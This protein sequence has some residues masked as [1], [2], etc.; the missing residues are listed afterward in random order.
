M[1]RLLRRL[2]FSRAFRGLI[3]GARRIVLPGFEGFDAY[4]IARLFFRALREGRLVTRASAISFKLFMAFFPAVL[5][6]LT[7]IPLIPVA[8]LQD[9]LLRM[10]RDLLPP[11]IRGFVESTLHDL[12][13]RPH[14]TLFSFSFVGGLYLASNSVDAILLGFSGS[15]NLT[16]WHSPWKQRLLSVLLLLVLSVLML[17]A[18]PIFATGN[19][20]IALLVRHHLLAGGLQVAALFTVK[21]IV[22]ILLVLLSVALLYYAGEPGRRR[23]RLFTPGA[24]LTVVLTLVLSQALA[25][26]FGTIT[27]YNALYGSIGAI[28]AVQLWLYLNMIVLLVG[29]EL[30]LS[31]SRARRDRSARLRLVPPPPPPIDRHAQASSRR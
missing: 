1:K 20:V 4:E 5:V 16:S 27:D 2:L 30:N 8:N 24:A 3:R 28:L 19:A 17:V 18:I 12:V 26:V 29:Y 7:A 31:I 13:V 9:D 23:F 14:G 21:W 10:F 25:Y 22:L 15:S 11:E 6:L